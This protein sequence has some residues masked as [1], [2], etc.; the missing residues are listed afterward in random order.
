MIVFDVLINF[1]N[2]SSLRT[3]H[4][5]TKFLFYNF[6][7]SLQSLYIYKTKQKESV[8]IYA[9]F[10]WWLLPSLHPNSLPYLASLIT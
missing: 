7:H 2:L 5:A 9:F 1:F 6:S 4:S 8:S 3:K 10:K